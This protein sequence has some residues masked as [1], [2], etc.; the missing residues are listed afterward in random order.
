[1]SLYDFHDRGVCCAQV[2]IDVGHPD[3][4]QVFF[5]G[6]TDLVRKKPAEVFIAQTEMGGDLI[7]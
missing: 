5:E 2:V 1:M 3:L 6:D 4:I 7:Q